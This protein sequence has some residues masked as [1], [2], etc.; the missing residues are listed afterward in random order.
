MHARIM[1]VTLKPERA[2]EA[3][4]QWAERVEKYYKGEGK[5]F[6]AGYML[7]V[8]AAAGEVLSITLWDNL[9]AIKA[10]E[11]S[12]EFEEAIRPYNDYFA[13]EPWYEYAEVGAK[14]V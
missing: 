10:N 7:I 3:Q 13:A 14:V 9:A 6:V 8:D 5:G 12:A 4:A 1:H 11:E 2:G